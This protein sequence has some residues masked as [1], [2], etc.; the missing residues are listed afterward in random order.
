MLE[1]EVFKKYTLLNGKYAQNFVFSYS[2]SHPWWF[3]SPEFDKSSLISISNINRTLLPNG[4]PVWYQSASL[5]IKADKQGST[6][7]RRHNNSEKIFIF[8]GTDP[9]NVE[10]LGAEVLFE[11]S[12][13][14]H[15]IISPCV[16]TI[17]KG[18]EYGGILAR[19]VD[20]PYVLI[21]ILPHA[22]FNG[23]SLNELECPA[24]Y[25]ISGIH[26]DSCSGSY[27][28]LFYRFSKELI[29]E[30]TPECGPYIGLPSVRVESRLVHF[31]TSPGQVVIA[32][33]DTCFHVLSLDPQNPHSLGTRAGC[34]IENELRFFDS[35][36][37]IFIPEGT[38]YVPPW[39]EYVS[40]PIMYGATSVYR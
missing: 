20:R 29:L 7:P 40:R 4:L 5:K 2:E 26:M 24:T 6:F 28:A 21:E 30:L 19:R 3:N 35:S 17:P 27:G 33:A 23:C 36:C 16:V 15:N 37:M 18:I 10:C 14:V 31:P 34:I 25:T 11:I 13:E 12:G 38:P 8:C 22:A 1:N 32:A 39:F 9:D